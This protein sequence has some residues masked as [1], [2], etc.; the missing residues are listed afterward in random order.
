MTS[1]H[2]PVMSNEVIRLF[3]AT[4]KKCFIDC[5]LGMGGHSRRILESFPSAHIIALD[6]DS[7]SLNQAKSNLSTFGERVEFHC[8]NFTNLFKQIDLSGKEISGILVDPGISMV[9]LKDPARGFS[10]SL[11][12]RLDMR[13]DQNGERTA[14]DVVNGYSEKQ[15]TEMFNN[16]GEIRQAPLLAKKIIETRLF[17]PIE[18]TTQLAAVIE[19]FY[20]WRPKK[21]RTHPASNVFQALRIEVNQELEG[22][23]EFIRQAPEYLTK[24]ACFIFLTFHSVEDRMVKQGFMQLKRE[25]KLEIIKPFP[26]IPSEEEVA[27]NL[28]S[29]SVKLRAGVIL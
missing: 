10:H 8:L 19:K 1:Q 6:V 16:Y 21:G 17:N 5:T 2:Y 11:E 27:E 22:V 13:K 14:Y 3:E 9:Q 25:D 12:G 28:P 15:L 20:K 23:A 29:R 7:H 18:T 4:G 24:G 26:A